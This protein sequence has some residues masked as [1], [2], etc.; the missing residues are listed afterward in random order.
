[1]G[2]GDD[3]YCFSCL[4]MC[5]YFA[6]KCCAECERSR[7]F[8]G[9][10]F[11]SSQPL[12]AHPPSCC[13]CHSSSPEC[14]M[15][16]LGYW[17]LISMGLAEGRS[18]FGGTDSTSDGQIVDGGSTSVVGPTISQDGEPSSSSILLDRTASRADLPS[19]VWQPLHWRR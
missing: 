9:R 11:A 18:W 5:L 6:G 12:D 8:T 2:W 13:S 15:L 1:M 16:L 19:R 3:L 7:G 4:L 14:Q 10:S 17:M